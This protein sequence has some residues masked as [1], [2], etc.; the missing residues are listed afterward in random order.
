MFAYVTRRFPLYFHDG[1]EMFEVG[2]TIPV[3]DLVDLQI[4]QETALRNGG[5]VELFTNL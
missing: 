3:A 5:W 4:M 1:I 2:R